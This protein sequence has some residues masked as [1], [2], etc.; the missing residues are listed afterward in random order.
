MRRIAL[1][2]DAHTR[3]DFRPN[4]A[5]LVDQVRRTEVPT[6]ATRHGRCS[7]VFLDVTGCASVA[8]RMD[9]TKE[10][11]HATEQVEHGEGIPHAQ[12]RRRL[13]SRVRSHATGHAR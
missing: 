7:E 5:D 1:D 3:S 12:V 6:V 11:D 13:L 9:V 2:A 4:L 10:I 8:D